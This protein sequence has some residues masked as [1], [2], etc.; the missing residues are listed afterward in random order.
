M[1]NAQ[2]ERTRKDGFA[3]KVEDAAAADCLR[4]SDKEG[5]VGGVLRA[6]IVAAQALAGRCPR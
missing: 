2:L 4:G 3:Q 5:A 1:A 6:P